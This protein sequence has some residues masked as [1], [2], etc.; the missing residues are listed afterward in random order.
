M[1]LSQPL[2]VSEGWIRRKKAERLSKQSGSAT[3]VE[4]PK[5]TDWV[6]D[7][8]GVTLAV[9]QLVLCKVAFDGVEPRDLEGE[10]RELAR[11]IFGEV[12]TI[13]KSARHMLAAMCGGRAGKSYILGGLRALY[14]SLYLPLVLA[15]GE[16]AAAIIVAPDIRLATQT[17]RYASG[18]ARS[19]PSIAR[20]I[21]AD[22]V[23]ALTLM[24]QDGVPIRIEALPASRGGSAVRGRVVACA[25]LDEA[26]FFRDG[27]YAIND[28][29]IY[30]AISPRIAPGGQL[31][32]PSTPW[33]E[34][35][36]LYEFFKRNYGH[37]VDALAAHAPTLVLRDDDH[38]REQVERERERDPDNAAREFDAVPMS[39]GTG[40]FFDHAMI[41]AC[42]DDDL[43]DVLAPI[44]GVRL[45]QGLDTGFRK[46]PSA[47]VI[48]R[49]GRAPGSRVEVAEVVEI[50]PTPGKPLVP[51]VTIK[52][53][54]DRARHHRCTNVIADQHYI[55][56][57]REHA[58]GF[59]LVEAPGGA[60]GKVE[61][62]LAAR[63]MIN[64]GRVRISAKHTRLLAQLRDIVA[65]P[66]PGGTISISSPRRAGAHGDIA[67]A[68]VLVLWAAHV[69]T[70]K[71]PVIHGATNRGPTA[72]LRRDRPSMRRRDR[73]GW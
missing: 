66:M 45:W 52:A 10:E 53:L 49:Q 15:P 42:I 55:E 37:P 6:R 47:A 43:P 71:T 33:A 59:S 41:A 29:E 23:E 13:P 17:L 12:D 9:G 24:R 57:V 48:G 40:A 73:S 28:E 14:L 26:C 64:E 67:S 31:I 4:A 69:G 2:P 16:R 22:T 11:I 61:A 34:S 32:V 65:R 62:H 5:F 25:V 18:A 54:L 56:S 20:L 50:A 7:T 30:K 72:D 63:T 60:P 68:F 27:S 1:S 44:E 19:C 21:T 51:S 70:G 46:D 36:L 8:L 38:I 3:A 39:A 58:S 35:G